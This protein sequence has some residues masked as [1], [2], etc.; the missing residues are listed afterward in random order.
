MQP[1]R[2]VVLIWTKA[3]QDYVVPSMYLGTLSVKFEL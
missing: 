3:V 2:R 1:A